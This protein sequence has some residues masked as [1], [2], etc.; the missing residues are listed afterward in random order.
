M[1]DTHHRATGVAMAGSLALAAHA[2]PA[3]GSVLPAL[4]PPLGVRDRL[5]DR[6]MVALTFDDGPD[7]RGTPAILEVL[8]AHAVTAT[9][10]VCGEQV[11]AAPA[12]AEEI[13]A[14]G[15]EIA[16]H[17]DRHRN[18][19]RVPPA[20]LARDLAD[21]EAAIVAA[22]A[23]APRLYRPP[24][25]V[26]SGAALA[27]ARRRGWQPLLW[28]RW[29]RDWRGAATASSVAAEVTRDLVGGE[30][31]LLHDA[32]RYSAPGSWRTT[33]AA[34]PIAIE[35][36]RERGLAFGGVGR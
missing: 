34:L 25:G 6:T 22:C 9:F 5:A 3:L 20:A 30:V 29:G 24:Y 17:G 19:L 7:P 15:H 23:R 28:T 26:L 12:L 33:A 8:R 27:I 31:L 2:G 35:R 13:V 4:R 32:D 36:V 1:N 18:L 10:F 21:A 14:A 11:R 16:V